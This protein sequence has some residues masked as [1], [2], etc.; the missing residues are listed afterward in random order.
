MSHSHLSESV[1]EAFLRATGHHDALHLV[2]GPPDS[3][4]RGRPFSIA[5]SRE[6]GTR[7]PAV[8]R[9][10]AERLGW[11]VYDH[12][13]L[14]LLARDLNVRVKLLE[15]VDERHITWLQECV[16][17]FAAV[18]AVREAKYVHHLIEIMLSLAARGRSVIVGRGSPFVLPCAT[19]LRVR[20]IAPLE[21]RIEVVCRERNLSRAEAARFVQVT[22]RERARFVMLHFQRDLSDALHY[23]LALNTAQFPIDQCASLIVDALQRKSYAHTAPEA[24][25]HREP[26]LAGA[27]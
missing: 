21:E 10:V 6:A 22:D 9:A 13:L 11:Q 24:S 4:R 26:I 2:A 12:E 8:A 7:G 19:T 27:P 20:L 15:D 1:S 25:A 16:E 23:D 5:I 14:E 17:A 18:P 3:V